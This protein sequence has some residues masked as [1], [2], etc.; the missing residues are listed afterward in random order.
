M[1]S[2][3]SKY[4][5]TPLASSCSCLKCCFT[6]WQLMFRLSQWSQ[7]HWWLNLAHQLTVRNQSSQLTFI[8]NLN[9]NQ[10][11]VYIHYNMAATTLVSAVAASRRISRAASS[12]VPPCKNWQPTRHR[13]WLHALSQGCSSL[14]CK[15]SA[16]FRHAA[17]SVKA[18]AFM[19]HVLEEN[20]T[21]PVESHRR[22]ACCPTEG[23]PA[24][25]DPRD[26]LGRPLTTLEFS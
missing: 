10:F 18:C 17:Q 24:S 4:N 14:L 16:A 25:H 12:S 8:H 9:W 6:V 26:N 13:S 2:L 1:L 23:S 22:A 3:F 19:S 15:T 5:E 21:T 11:T 20:R 7:R